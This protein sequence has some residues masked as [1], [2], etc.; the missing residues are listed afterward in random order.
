MIAYP[1]PYGKLAA[2]DRKRKPNSVRHSPSLGKEG[3][4]SESG[5]QEDF[6]SA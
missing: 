4:R 6:G 2:A 5:S 3:E 1:L